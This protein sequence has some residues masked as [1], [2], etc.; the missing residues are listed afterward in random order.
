[1]RFVFSRRFFI[2]LA[3]GLIP[4]SFSWNLP[5]LRPFVVAYDIL[6][7]ALAFLDYFI[8][9]KLPE[10]LTVH[11]E[12]NRKFAIGDETEVRLIVENASAKDFYLKI[13]DEFPP[14]MRLNETREA[15]FPVEAQTTAE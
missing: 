5:E 2:L 13:K 4:L 3:I 1:M 9:R 8:S 12:F 10:E 6:L 7:V 14:E 11:R 15:E